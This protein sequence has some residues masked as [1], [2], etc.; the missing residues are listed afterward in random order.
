MSYIPHELSED[1]P[2]HAEKL[3]ELKVADPHF[4]RLAFEYH[5][6][7]REVHLIETG[8]EP[9]AVEREEELRKTRM[10]LK[11]EIAGILANA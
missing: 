3:H 2:E 9:A 7:N 8:V 6:V 11:D 10:L 5:Q 4:A 1:F